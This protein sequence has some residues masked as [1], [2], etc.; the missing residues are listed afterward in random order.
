MIAYPE[1]Y[2]GVMSNKGGETT[3]CQMK[4]TGPGK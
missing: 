4:W 1:P 3:V 2:C